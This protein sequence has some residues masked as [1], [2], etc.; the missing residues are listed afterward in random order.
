MGDSAQIFPAL[1]GRL[2]AIA[3][4]LLLTLGASSTAAAAPQRYRL[5][6][7]NGNSWLAVVIDE[8]QAD[9]L[10][11]SLRL[12]ATDSDTALDHRAAMTMSDAVDHTWTLANTSR[13]M[14]PDNETPMPQESAQ[15]SLAALNPVP[16]DTRPLIL[17]VPLDQEG[18]AVIVSDPPFTAALHGAGR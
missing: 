18:E 12:T 11:W 1:A 5:H 13:S 17:H 15:F 16:A 9:G 8:P 6:D 14:V 2:L 3:L 4:S 7:Q 10:H